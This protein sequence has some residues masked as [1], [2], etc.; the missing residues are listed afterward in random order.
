MIN[1]IQKTVHIYVASTKD[2][3]TKIQIEEI[4]DY[5]WLT[6]ENALKNLKFENDKTILTEARKFLLDNNYIS[7]VNN[8]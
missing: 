6:Y 1:R 5:I 2:T 7:E 3:Q 4:E 8:G